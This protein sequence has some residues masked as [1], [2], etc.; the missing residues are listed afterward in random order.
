MLAL[1]AMFFAGRT[2]W[3]ELA[4]LPVVRM[5]GIFIAFL[6]L[7]ALY[8]TWVVPEISYSDQ[9]STA[10]KLVRL[11]VFCCAVG[12]WLSVC[13]RAIP[14]LLGLMV[15]GLLVAVLYHMPWHALPEI[16]DG[17]MRPRFGIPENL[18]GQ[19]AAVGGWLALCLL[20]GIWRDHPRGSRRN[21]LLAVGFA[22]YAGSFCVLLFSQSRGAWLAFLSA[23]PL[24]ILGYWLTRRPRGIRTLP[25][26]P[27]T[28][29]IVISVLLVLGARDIFA[30]RFAG[31]DRMLPVAEEAAGAVKPAD[32]QS[33]TD[34]PHRA[35]SAPVDH[36]SATAATPTPPAR[37]TA[38]SS[39]IDTTIP[40]NKA[41]GIRVRLYELGVEKFRERPWL[42]WGLDSTAALIDSAKL[43]LAGE[44]HVHLHNSYLDALVGMGLVGSLLLLTLFVLVIRELVLAWGGGIISTA[45]FW[46]LAGCV[47]IVLVANAFDSLL[48]RFEY[49][50][51]PQELLFGCCI[52][53]ALIRRRERLPESSG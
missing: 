46:A 16:W 18:S 52:A 26:Q 38:V 36:A 23:T 42:G 21:W 3:R 47:G 32:S 37:D 30:N 25:W 35:S 5:L 45:S 22:A 20:I 9:L 44:R 13:P 15:L 27:I 7:H 40:G 11:G 50:R 41:I 39:T 12:W 34:V 24:A 33:G 17:E 28:L 6:I 53:Y 29:A 8:A 49:A 48:W 4:S 51:A 14:G 2:P 19:L 10:S 43:D 1:L 31:A